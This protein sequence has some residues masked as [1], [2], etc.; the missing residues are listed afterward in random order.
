MN[1]KSKAIPATVSALL[2]S[3]AMTVNV[4]L[5]SI[6]PAGAATQNIPYYANGSL[7]FGIPPNGQPQVNP[8][9][10]AFLPVAC[11]GSQIYSSG[12][13]SGPYTAKGDINIGGGSDPNI[14][15]YSS[16]SASSA[17]AQGQ[18]EYYL[19]VIPHTISPAPPG[20]DFTLHFDGTMETGPQMQSQGTYSST[21]VVFYDSS[22]N[23]L[24]TK[25]LGPADSGA[26]K[27]DY[28]YISTVQIGAF[29][30]VSMSALANAYSQRGSAAT[31]AL[32]DPIITLQGP[33]AN[34]YMIV[35]SPG[36]LDGVS[37]AVPEPPTWTI[38]LLGLAGICFVTNRRRSTPASM[39][40]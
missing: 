27:T 20:N 34:Q 39:A 14:S 4:M 35:Y 1:L 30:E 40:A 8:P 2:A 31:Y 26:V 12:A 28:Q 11:V 10:G 24:Y 23:A 18:L 32:I 37:T 38:L 9:C 22:Y 33:D 16:V 29:Y 6:G 15:V 3:C 25:T 36:L 17:I 13:G 19:W 21:G 5:A 7:S